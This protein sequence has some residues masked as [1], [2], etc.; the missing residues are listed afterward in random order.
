MIAAIAIFSLL[1]AFTS[2]RNNSRKIKASVIVFEG[3]SS[4]FITKEEVNK[5]LIQNQTSVTDVTKDALDLNNMESLLLRNKMIKDAEVYMTIDGELKVNVTQRKPLARVVGTRSFYIDDEGEEMPLSGNYTARVPLINGQV[6]NENKQEIFKV[7]KKI[8]SDNFLKVSVIG[9]S[10]QK[11]DFT[12][13]MRANNFK[14]KLGSADG[15]DLKFKKLKAFYQK[16]VKDKSLDT[17]SWVN[18]KFSN[19]VVCTKK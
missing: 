4:L 2:N 9:I 8:T 7:L 11:N 19:Q 15:L 12:L 18:L 16:A 3:D 1:F 10:V 13:R 17:Y 14:V 5:L 6:T